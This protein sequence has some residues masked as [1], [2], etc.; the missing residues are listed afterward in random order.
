VKE[1]TEY[2]VSFEGGDI[3]KTVVIYKSKS[4][5]TK[6]YAQWLAEALQADLFEA[7]K[8]NKEQF[9]AYDNVIYGGGIYAVGINGIKFIKENLPSL[10]GKKVIVFATGLSPAREEVINEIKDK[11][12]SAEELGAISFF[13]MR[14]GFDTAKLKTL[15]GLAMKLMRRILKRK[16]PAAMSEDDRSM[17]DAFEQPVDFTDKRNIEPILKALEG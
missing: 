9:G 5:Y 3:M 8:F 7:D 2:L 6:K 10:K 11:N 17:L 15:D 14:G 16:D 13:Y 1:L 4:G 12:F